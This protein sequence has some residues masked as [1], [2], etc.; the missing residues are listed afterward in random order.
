M[1]RSAPLD[2]QQPTRGLRAS[3]AH[4]AARL[5]QRVVRLCPISALDPSVVGGGA[6]DPRP[7]LAGARASSPPGRWRRR[8]RRWSIPQSSGIAA[9]ELVTAILEMRGETGGEVPTDADLRSEE[10]GALVL[11]RPETDPHQQF[12]CTP[13]VDLPDEAELSRAGL[14]GGPTA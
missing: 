5:V 4:A 2:P 1:P 14:R 9:E 7:V 8:S 10:Y 13:V 3:A 11:G 12:V 6:Q